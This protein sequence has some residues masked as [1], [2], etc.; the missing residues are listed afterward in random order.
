VPATLA[1]ELKPYYPPSTPTWNFFDTDDV[2]SMNQALMQLDTFIELEGP[3]DAVIAYS[4]GAAFAATYI[5]RAALD[6]GRPPPFQCALFFSAAKPADP[7]ELVQG[8][9]RYLDPE[10]DGIRITVPTVHVW[11]ENDTLHPDSWKNAW[12]LSD[13]EMKE[14]VV[15][16]EGHGIPGGKAREAVLEIAKKVRRMVARIE[17]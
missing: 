2:A 3:F 15:H 4:H 7:I 16:R 17:D 12:E 10:R 8:N 1:E 13:P 6:G 14:N 9:L 11:G 5:V